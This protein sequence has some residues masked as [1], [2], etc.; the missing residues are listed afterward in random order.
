MPGSPWKARP[1]RAFL[2]Q[3]VVV[4]AVALFVL[5]LV[6]NTLDNL[7]DRKIASGFGF[8]SSTAGFGIDN[9]LIA[10]SEE[11]S[12]GRVFL[13]G[14]LNTLMVSAIGIVIATV[15]GVAIGVARLSPNWLLS[16]MAGAY[17][18]TLRNIP[19]LLQIFFWYLIALRGLPVP[20]DSFSLGDVVFLNNR[21]LY[22]PS[23]DNGDLFWL[24]IGLA[25]SVLVFHVWLRRVLGKAGLKRL[26]GVL[27]ILLLIVVMT[28]EWSIPTLRRFNFTGGLVLSPELVTLATAL[29]TY[30][31]AFIAEIVRAGIQSVPKGQVEAARALGLGPAD[32]MWRVVLPQALRVIVPPLTNQYL[33]LTKNSSLA[34]AT[35]FPDLVSVF[36]GTAMSITGQAVQMITLVM[37]VYLSISLGIALVM[38][39]YNRVVGLRGI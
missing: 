10:Y 2:W 23:A 19:L 26:C 32:V 34:A 36:L 13:V 25:V 28:V 24:W 27:A 1:A 35:A 30:T 14:L 12:I 31:A 18:E 5:F 6:V 9:T 7:A 8:M 16:R 39:F 15:A 29:A 22:L 20:R 33:N 21:G 4:A 17:V 37:A 11:S 3:V 38:N